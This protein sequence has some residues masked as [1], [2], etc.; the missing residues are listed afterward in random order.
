MHRKTLSKVTKT[1][2]TH[3]NTYTLR[4]SAI[5]AYVLFLVEFNH[6]F[7]TL[8][9]RQYMHIGEKCEYFYNFH[10]KKFYKHAFRRLS[11]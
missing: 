4:I 6:V 5:N 2:L 3:R 1:Y 10:E 7:V 8:E 11:K 9:K